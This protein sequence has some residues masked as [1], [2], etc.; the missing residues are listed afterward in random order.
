MKP[1]A[2]QVGVAVLLVAGLALLALMRRRNDRADA[3]PAEDDAVS[4]FLDGLG[5]SPAR[6]LPA[7]PEETVNAFYDAAGAGDD[8]AFLALL[9]T[10]LRR[11]LARTRDQQGARKFRQDLR[12][13]VAGIKGL[14]VS[15]AK[16]PLAGEAALDVELI[17]ADRT[18][19]QRIGLW[20]TGNGWIITSLGTSW[21]VK[22]PVP[23]G[24]PVYQE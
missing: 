20:R 8:E 3:P 14:A 1:R 2:V 21:G 12:T 5:G 4:A 11:R 9:A 23:Y 18:D 10:D 19:R 6:T 7:T 24:T 22:P 13:S 15:R 17:F 16:D